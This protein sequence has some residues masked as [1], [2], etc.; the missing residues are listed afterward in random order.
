MIKGFFKLQKHKEFNFTPRYYNEDK[1]RLEQRYNEIANEQGVTTNRDKQIVRRQISFR[2]K[3]N[4]SWKMANH[5]R[6]NKF[7][8]LRLLVILGVL[9]AAF[10][11]IYLNI[12]PFINNIV[13]YE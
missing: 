13:N 7:S 12:E 4:D 6:Q 8:N 1:E 11:F 3:V 10:Y 9:I 5:S 2:E